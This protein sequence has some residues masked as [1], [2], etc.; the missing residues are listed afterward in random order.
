MAR[1]FFG[2]E[3]LLDI[4]IRDV[5]RPGAVA[6]ARVKGD[7]IHFV[8]RTNSFVLPFVPVSLKYLRFEDG[9]AVF[10]LAIVSG[11]V[12]K[13]VGRLNQMLELKIPA[14]MRL[15]YPNLSIDID[16]LLAEKSV[17]GVRVKDISFENG[18]FTVITENV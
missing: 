13:A 15:D 12:K 8:I 9:H 18:E 1:I 16:K 2:F 11:R 4:L 14:Y 7:R 3:E 6:R 10:E 5:L 17:R